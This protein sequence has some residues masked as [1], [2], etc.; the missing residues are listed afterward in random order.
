MV[1]RLTYTY[2]RGEEGNHVD[3]EVLETVTVQ[4]VQ[5]RTVQMLWQARYND[6]DE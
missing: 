4:N 3:R 6:G 5:L 2:N 1:D